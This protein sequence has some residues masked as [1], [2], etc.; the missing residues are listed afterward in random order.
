MRWSRD[1][2]HDRFVLSGMGKLHLEIAIHRLKTQYK[3]DAAFGDI[4]VDYKECLTAPTGEHRYEYDRVVASKAGKAACVASLEPRDQHDEASILESS[5]ER[6]GNLFHIKIIL[7]EDGELPFD[8]ELVRKQ[9]FNGA[10]A[11]MARGPRRG[12][13]MH[14]CCVSITFDPETDFFGP[15]TDGHIVNAAYNAVRT[16]LN[17]AHSQS[18]V[19]ILEPVMKANISCP[20]EAAGTIQHDIAS[21]RGGQ[22]LEVNDA[23]VASADS[24]IDLNEVYAPPDPYESLQSLRDAKKGVTRML[25]IVA[26]VPLKEM[27]DYDSL[28]RSK[29]GGRHS[30][31]MSLDTFDRVTGPREKG[32]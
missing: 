22:V 21:A 23:N 15:G 5:T 3:V 2:K 17:S 25:D 32:L 24:I 18:A 13:P 10:Y 30:L 28:L 11:A 9:L 19:G 16:A 14:S 31:T 8:P 6:D 7:P 27:L 26:K 12:S 20:E 29:T 4:E 1:E